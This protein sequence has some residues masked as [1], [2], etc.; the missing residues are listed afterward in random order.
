MKHVA[1]FFILIYNNIYK[2]IYNIL[3][4]LLIYFILIFI[5]FS[6]F[7]IR[8]YPGIFIGDKLRKVFR[9]KGR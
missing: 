3:Y 2:I 6:Y 8:S 7:K 9:E 4:I 5:I 1:L